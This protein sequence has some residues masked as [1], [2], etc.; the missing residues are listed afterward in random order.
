MKGVF[1]FLVKYSNDVWFIKGE[2]Y[3]ARGILY[4]FNTGSVT[5]LR[6][7]LFRIKEGDKVLHLLL[8]KYK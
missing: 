4:F 5:K 1:F 6:S 7:N 2:I 8:N 3:W